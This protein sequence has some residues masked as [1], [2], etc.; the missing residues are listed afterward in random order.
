MPSRD[1]ND[2]VELLQLVWTRCSS[3]YAEKYP[4]GPQVFLTCT[5]R[6]NEEQ[7]ALYAQGRSKPG[8]IVTR[9]REN[10]KHNVYPSKAFDIAFKKDGKLDWSERNFKNFAAIVAAHF[11]SVE[12]GG[13][14]PRFKDLPH[15]Q[16]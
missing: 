5:H 12:W 9:I 11:P 15:F 6:T 14:W 2:C 4:E 16:V 3:E 7:K 13:N 1:I 8:K 10:G